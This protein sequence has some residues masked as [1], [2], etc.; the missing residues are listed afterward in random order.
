MVVDKVNKLLVYPFR[1]S[2]KISQMRFSHRDKAF[3]SFFED[4]LDTFAADQNIH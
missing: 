2:C 3:W 1:L 4:T